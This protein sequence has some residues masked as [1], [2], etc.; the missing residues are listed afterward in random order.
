MEKDLIKEVKTLIADVDKTHRYSMSKIYGLSN[1]VFNKNE[2][3][4]SCAS[5]LIRKVDELRKW[6]DQQERLDVITE[7]IQAEKPKRKRKEA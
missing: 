5:C 6:L 1:K 7:E 2:Q 4:Q 3:P